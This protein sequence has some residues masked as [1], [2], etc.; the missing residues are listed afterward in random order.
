[1]ELRRVQAAGALLRLAQESPGAVLL[2]ASW[3]AEAG[4]LNL[5][6]RKVSLPEAEAPVV[7]C[8]LANV[9]GR[10]RHLDKAQAVAAGLRLLM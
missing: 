1:M 3:L 5:Q 2:E 9:H 7:D 4:E 8:L 6:E 10:S